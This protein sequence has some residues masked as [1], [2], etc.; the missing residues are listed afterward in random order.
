M[1]T[2]GNQETIEVGE[3]EHMNDVISEIKNNEW[4]S[5]I[6]YYL[7]NLTCHEHAVDHKRMDLRLKS[8][9]YC[10]T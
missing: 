2:E 4:Y 1:L 8:M 6:I 9:K 7:K 3:R 10:L 5:Y